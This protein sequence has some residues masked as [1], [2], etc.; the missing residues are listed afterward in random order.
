MNPRNIYDIEIRG[1]RYVGKTKL[2]STIAGQRPPPVVSNQL[3]VPVSEGSPYHVSIGYQLWDCS[4]M[5]REMARMGISPKPD[6]VIIVVD[7]SRPE[8]LSKAAEDLIPVAYISGV[9][10]FAVIVN[11]IPN[12]VEKMTLLHV[13]DY[14]KARC[15]LPFPVY[16]FEGNV[17]NYTEMAK[18]VKTLMI[19]RKEMHE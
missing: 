13:R 7:P 18:M 5:K 2:F 3:I 15:N 8:T 4:D 16:V 9:R 11:H 10:L 19:I 1:D 12:R 17:D 14:I 6:T